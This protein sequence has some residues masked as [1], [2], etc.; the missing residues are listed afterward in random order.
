MTDTKDVKAE[1]EVPQDTEIKIQKLLD[2]YSKLS[3][4]DKQQVTSIRE[5]MEIQLASAYNTRGMSA[6]VMMPGWQ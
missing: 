5:L 6:N 1:E 3:G 4:L 2:E